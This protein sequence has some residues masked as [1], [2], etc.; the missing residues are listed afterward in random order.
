MVN[1]IVQHIITDLKHHSRDMIVIQTVDKFLL[2]K[3]V[4]EA[5]KELGVEIVSGTSLDIRLRYELRE[6]DMLFILVT[7]NHTYIAEDILQSAAVIPFTLK[8]YLRFYHQP[9]VENESLEVLDSLLKKSYYTPLNKR[10]TQQV[11][12]EVKRDLGERTHKRTFDLEVF[13]SQIGNLLTEEHVNWNVISVMIAQAFA[14][15]IGSPDFLLL[16]EKIDELNIIFQEYLKNNY[17]QKQSASY[18]KRPQIVSRV[19]DFLDLKH[20]KD[21]VALIVVDSM[22]LWQY[23]LME[24]FLP[25]TK[26]HEVIYSWL[27]SITQL[28]RQAIFRGDIPHKE[29]QQNPTNE[30]KLWFEFWMSKGLNNS[31]I[32][33]Q[34]N[35]LN[36]DFYNSV[37]KLAVVLT[38]LDEQMHGLTN[39]MDLKSIT[40]NWMTQGELSAF[41]VALLDKEFKVFLTSDH[42]NIKAKGLRAL[43]GREKPGT[44]SSGSRSQRHIEY[45]EPWL[46]DEFLESNPYL[47][48][49]LIR[50]ENA[51]CLTSNDSFSSKESHITHGGAHLFEVLIPFV[52]I[53]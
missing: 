38:H 16:Q 33:Y 8:K 1:G 24:E 4:E 50:N 22:T 49:K 34:H 18:V 31:Q 48:D 26:N 41:I 5:F 35:D 42:G 40:Q 12:Q 17:K 6:P 14:E 45:T 28:S 37:N 13:R 30:S 51:I 2:R 19:L 46:M 39:Y 23:Q 29:Y 10:E 43:T 36:L 27:P 11:L 20:N 9:T 7:D 52:E 32:H 3:D 44:H 21:K 47:T 25:G 53:V 15:L